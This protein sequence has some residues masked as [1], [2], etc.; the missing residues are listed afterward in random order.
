V[1]VKSDVTGNHF[2]AK[3]SR[4]QVQLPRTALRSEP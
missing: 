3:S 1:R 2:V 4:T